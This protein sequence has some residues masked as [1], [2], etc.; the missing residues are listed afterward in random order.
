MYVGL[1]RCVAG[2]VFGA[3]VDGGGDGDFAI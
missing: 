1:E 3:A 2:A